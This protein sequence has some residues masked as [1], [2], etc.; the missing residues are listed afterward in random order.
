MIQQ[1]HVKPSN[2]L[3]N[4]VLCSYLNIDMDYLRTDCWYHRY[5]W[6]RNKERHNDHY[7]KAIEDAQRLFD[8]MMQYQHSCHEG[9]FSIGELDCNVGLTSPRKGKM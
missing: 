1:G 5:V 2:V 3:Y 8:E 4:L 6:K 9:N 7:M